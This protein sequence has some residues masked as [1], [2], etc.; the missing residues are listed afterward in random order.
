MRLELVPQ[1]SKPLNLD[2]IETQLSLEKTRN[3]EKDKLFMIYAKQWWNDYLQIRPDSH[4]QRLVKIYAMDELNSSY[5]AK[6]FLIQIR[7]TYNPVFL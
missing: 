2:V 4:K 1:L 3:S 5:P 7:L 6:G